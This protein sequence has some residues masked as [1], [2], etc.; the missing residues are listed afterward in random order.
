MG[1]IGYKSEG[2]RRLAYQANSIRRIGY[3]AESVRRTGYKA[4]CVRILGYRAK[5]VRISE[6]NGPSDAGVLDDDVPSALKAVV[7]AR[8]REIRGLACS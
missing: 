3:R 7:E 5:S 4:K 6:R 1:K 2:L 8:A